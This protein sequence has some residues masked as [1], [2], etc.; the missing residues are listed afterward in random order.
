[1]NIKI[2]RTMCQKKPRV[3][4]SEDMINNALIA[5]ICKRL[6]WRLAGGWRMRSSISR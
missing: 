5:Q 2:P 6:H 4:S 3:K 1:M